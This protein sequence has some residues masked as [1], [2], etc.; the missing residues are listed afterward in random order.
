M[1]DNIT[2]KLWIAVELADE[3]GAGP[4]ATIIKGSDWAVIPGQEFMTG[5]S[6]RGTET[7]E[8]IRGRE[9]PDKD[10]NGENIIGCRKNI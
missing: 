5:T 2:R 3:G 6:S 7:T 1:T 9:G 4:K 10:M 8:D